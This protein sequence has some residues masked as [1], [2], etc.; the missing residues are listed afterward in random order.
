M[1]LVRTRN[2]LVALLVTLSLAFAFVAL[3]GPTDVAQADACT[4]LHNHG[5]NIHGMRIDCNTGSWDYGH[6]N[7]LTGAPFWAPWCSEEWTDHYY[8][9]NDGYSVGSWV[10]IHESKVANIYSYC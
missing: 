8:R 10:L 9:W 6:R 1:T 2:I 4:G 5:G 3:P 7:Y